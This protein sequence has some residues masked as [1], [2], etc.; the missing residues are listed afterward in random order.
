[1]M[2]CVLLLDIQRW[3]NSPHSLNAA[4]SEVTWH[5]SQ[6]DPSR[7]DFVDGWQRPP[8]IDG[9]QEPGV[10]IDEHGSQCSL[11]CQD[12]FLAAT[13]PSISCAVA[14]VIVSHDIYKQRQKSQN[15]T[16]G[17]AWVVCNITVQTDKSSE[18]QL[19]RELVQWEAAVVQSRRQPVPHCGT[20]EA[21]A[22]L[23]GWRQHSQQLQTSS[24]CTP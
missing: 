17:T 1:M 21:E 7:P 15:A 6:A 3:S 23:A 4:K 16:N 22:P 11:L 13:D 8:A 18:V 2:D 5:G 19:P 14:I 24:R 20:V 10:Y 9:G 12:M